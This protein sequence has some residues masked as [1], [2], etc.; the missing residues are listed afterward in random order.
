M[1]TA[2]HVGQPVNVGKG[3]A[4]RICAS[5][6]M[7]ASVGE[8]V[9]Q[10]MDLRMAFAPVRSD[11]ARVFRKWELVRESYRKSERAVRNRVSA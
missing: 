1:W 9:A 10:G 7:I 3:A 4:L 2:C 8:R 11:L 6:P 5:M